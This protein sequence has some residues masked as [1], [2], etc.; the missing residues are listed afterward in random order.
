MTRFYYKSDEDYKTLKADLEDG[1]LRKYK[2]VE[3]P[4]GF[5]VPSCN[6]GIEKYDVDNSTYVLYIDLGITCSTAILRNSHPLLKKLLQK[7]ELHFLDF[8]DMKVFLKGLALS[9]YS[10]AT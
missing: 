5:N 6:I 2:N 9:I 7:G 4:A 1:C 10:G 3:L 8:N